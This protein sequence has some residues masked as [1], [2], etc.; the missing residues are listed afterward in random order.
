MTNIQHSTSKRPGA[1]LY[2]TLKLARHVAYRNT[3]HAIAEIVDNSLDAGA[4][5]VQI[6]LVE[7]EVMNK[8]KSTWQVTQI[9]VIDDGTG[10]DRDTLD[11][12]ITISGSRSNN[13]PGK[14]GQF[15]YGLVY[16]SIYTCDRLDLWSWQDFGPTG[17]LHS[18]ID[19]SELKDSD[20]ASHYLPVQQGLPEEYRNLIRIDSI[21]SG[22]V[23]RWSSLRKISWKRSQTVMDKSESIM[24]RIYRKRLAAGPNNVDIFFTTAREHESGR[25]EVTEPRRSVRAND[26]MYLMRNTNTPF[27][28]DEPLFQGIE[29]L[30]HQTFDVGIGDSHVGTCRVVC[31]FVNKSLLMTRCTGVESAGS[32]PYGRHAYENRGFS[33]VREN[34]ELCLC[35]QL[36]KQTQDRWWGIEVLFDKELDDFFGVTSDKQRAT[37]FE[38][39]LSE[40]AN[41]QA[42]PQ[43]LRSYEDEMMESS[44]YDAAMIRLIRELNEKRKF[45]YGQVTKGGGVKVTSDG[46]KVSREELINDPVPYSV[47]DSVSAKASEA[48]KRYQ[49]L[50]PE[51]V[52]QEPTIDQ[53]SDEQLEELRRSLSNELSEGLEGPDED[54]AI[55]IERL[56]NFKRD[57]IFKEGYL[58]DSDAFISPKPQAF[59]VNICMIN[60]AHPFYDE[61]CEAL[62]ILTRDNAEYLKEMTHEETKNLLVRATTGLYLSFAC[63]CELENKALGNEKKMLRDARISWGQIVRDY[64]IAL[65]VREREL[66]EA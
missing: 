54:T 7:K 55:D 59:G 30:D 46:H 62:K 50:H 29:G 60:T 27:F 5:Q 31:S 12:A 44:E 21:G 57:F 3:D 9:L 43:D 64:L 39:C 13:K 36:A 23:V 22:T 47:M 20:R 45:L 16:S 63:W 15:G 37:R 38:E 32:T 34:R 2:E 56:I 18:Y 8:T 51:Q 66:E 26:P 24:G 28:Q 4:R 65:G 1:P 35:P 41:R 6:V 17:A 40:Y 11:Q 61:I 53:A 14:I 49:E 19:M 10:M 25:I 58:S 33:L 52:T 48:K 42:S